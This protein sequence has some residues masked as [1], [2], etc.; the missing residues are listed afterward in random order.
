MKLQWN[1]LL[2]LTLIKSIFYCAILFVGLGIGFTFNDWP[3]V[4]FKKEISLDKLFDVGL[5]V[6]VAVW[7]PFFINKKITKK[8]IEKD[9]LVEACRKH[10]EKEIGELESMIEK[11]Y[12]KKNKIVTR[13]ANE[14]ISKTKRVSNRLSLLV[15]DVFHYSK[16]DRLMKVVGELKNDQIRLGLITED[17]RN[18]HPKI[19]S[20]SYTKSI[21]NISV[22]FKHMSE[23]RMLINDV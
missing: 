17:L 2:F 10:E 8:S 13:E 1:R 3:N 14:I 4:S 20:E 21:R 18:S 6:F 12:P 16:D 22:Y 5:A 15:G 23:L 9:L 11:V 7:V 19:T